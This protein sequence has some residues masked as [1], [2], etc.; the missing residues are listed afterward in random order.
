MCR[1]TE[2]TKLQKKIEM[3]EEENQLLKSQLKV[4]KGN[5]I[6][7]KE[8]HEDTTKHYKSMLEE[9]SLELR[10]L[11]T[12]NNDELD[13]NANKRKE[14]NSEIESLQKNPENV[15]KMKLDHAMDDILNLKSHMAVSIPN[16]K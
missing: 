14:N 7:L 15:L 5:V 2:T 6:I 11:I 12:N 9:T 13:L 3:L 4:E 16:L 1:N 8:Q 10:K